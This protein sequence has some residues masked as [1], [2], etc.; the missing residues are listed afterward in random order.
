MREA[1]VFAKPDTLTNRAAGVCPIDVPYAYFAG[2]F[3]V[4]GKLTAYMEP[5]P[6]LY[7]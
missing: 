7:R 2:V 3:D 4:N 1:G 6:M 5:T